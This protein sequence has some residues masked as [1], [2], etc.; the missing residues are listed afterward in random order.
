MEAGMSNLL[1]PSKWEWDSTEK[2]RQVSK[3]DTMTDVTSKMYM[4]RLVPSQKR[5]EKEV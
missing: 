5:K 3:P 2:V 4:G 1:R